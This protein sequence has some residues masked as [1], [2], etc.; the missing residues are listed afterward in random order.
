MSNRVFKHTAHKA[1]WDWIAN[2]PYLTYWEWPG[3]EHNGGECEPLINDNF[4]CDYAYDTS[5]DNEFINCR[6]CPLDQWAEPSVERRYFSYVESE[7]YRGDAEGLCMYGLY[8]LWCDAY[9]SRDLEKIS[10]FAKKIR[11]L[12][13]KRHIVC[14]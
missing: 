10:Y 3:W 13:V 9:Y 5:P 2:N 1:L 6:N 14:E 12:P 11:D 7:E 8:G 4:A